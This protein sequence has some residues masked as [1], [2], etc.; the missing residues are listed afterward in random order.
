[1]L[2][3]I[4]KEIV[5]TSSSLCISILH[6]LVFSLKKEKKTKCSLLDLGLNFGESVWCHAYCTIWQKIEKEV[7]VILHF[8]QKTRV[9]ARLT[10]LLTEV[11]YYNNCFVLLTIQFSH[12]KYSW[13]PFPMIPLLST[14]R[15]CS[16]LT[17]NV[18]SSSTVMRSKILIVHACLCMLLTPG[19]A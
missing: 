15:V 16:W 2:G 17:L 4:S 3:T 6:V 9:C 11:Q 10:P 13:C 8:N 19:K 14:K 1:M 18:I 7:V 12:K 5:R